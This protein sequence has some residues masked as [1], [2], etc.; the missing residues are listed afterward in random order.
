MVEAQFDDFEKSVI[1]R[2]LRRV[3]QDNL[4]GGSKHCA[5]AQG[6]VEKILL[7]RRLLR[8]PELV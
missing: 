5:T 2:D 4:Q 1:I 7:K 8:S 3:N 6:F